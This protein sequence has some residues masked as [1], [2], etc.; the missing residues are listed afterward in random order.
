MNQTNIIRLIIVLLV[1]LMTVF[2]ATHQW[3]NTYLPG[4]W[5]LLLC[6]VALWLISLPI[7]KADIIDIFWGFGFVVYIWTLAFQLDW[8]T[9]G[10]RQWVLMAIVSV[11]GL[12][13]TIYL[14]FRNLGKPED[15]RYAAWRKENGKNW[16]WFSY[17]KVFGLQSVLIWI[18]GAVYL[19]ALLIKGDL[20]IL[21]YLGIGFWMIGFFFEAVGD[22]QMTQ[23]KKDLSNKG[24]VMNK[25]L[26]R[27]TRHPNY[28]GDAMQWWGYFLFALAHPNGWIFIICPLM[29]TFF[30][31]KVS[32][33]AMLEEGMVKTKAKYKDYI[34][35]T[36]AFIPWF[37]KD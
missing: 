10:L 27:Y 7:K 19:P 3:A 2:L 13:L 22:W 35:N 20:Q 30:L 24:K 9:F 17:V 33:V 34:A 36:P 37:P 28:F 26:W 23:F 4:L 15:Y 32:G 6:S 1:V 5:V 21:D 14:A 12:R 18:I 8:D 25:G 31:L 29:M 16:W 11:W